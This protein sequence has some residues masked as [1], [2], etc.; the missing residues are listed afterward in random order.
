MKRQKPKE[1]RSD[2]RQ[3]NRQ[4]WYRQLRHQDGLPRLL[5]DVRSWTG[6]GSNV[7]QDLLAVKLGPF[8]DDTGGIWL[9]YS[10]RKDIL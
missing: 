6:E 10:R 2:P 7:A 9:Q 1:R 5:L 8:V 3:E 4:R